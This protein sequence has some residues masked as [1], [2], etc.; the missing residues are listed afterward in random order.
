LVGHLLSGDS[1]DEVAPKRAHTRANPEGP[2]TS[3]SNPE[4][5]ISKGKAL[6]RQ[7]SRSAAT[8]DSG[9]LIDSHISVSEKYFETSA[10][11]QKF[12]EIKSSSQAARVKEPSL[13]SNIIDS[14]LEIEF[15]SRPKEHPSP[16]SSNSS[17]S[18]LSESILH[19]YTHPSV[20]EEIIQDLSSKGE[21]NLAS[22]LSRF[23]K[24][25]YFPSTFETA[26]MNEVRRAFISNSGNLSPPSSPP[27]HPSPPLSPSSSS[28][29]STIQVIMA[30]QTQTRMEQILANRYAPLILPNPLSSMPTGDYQKYMPKFTGAGEYTA[31][32]HIEAFYAYAENINISEEDVWTRVFIQSF[33]GQ[34]RKWF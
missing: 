24:A 9:I 3:V 13:S 5:I 6:H 20:L 10:E 23:Y 12:K 15:S 14:S 29:S 32:E 2:L 16:S 19:T 28:S 31:E 17:P 26:L 7:A 22:F 30:G 11:I 34:A 33:D 21:G 4:K 8:I 18:K 25:S 27:N 1:I